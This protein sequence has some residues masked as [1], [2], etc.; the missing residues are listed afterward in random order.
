VSDDRLRALFDVMDVEGTEERLRDALAAETTAAGRAEVL[1]QLAR[2][3]SWLDR[4]DE[5]RAL[6]EE[7]DALAGESGVARARVLLERGRLVRRTEGN[8]AALPLL[9]RGY[10]AALAA[11]QFFVAADA[12]HTCALAGDMPLWTSRG[13]EIAAAHDGA[14]YWRGTLLINL[15]DWQWARGEQAASLATAQAALEAREREAWNPVTEEARYG[16][17]RAL[18]ALGRPAEAIPLLEQVV[19]WL[20]TTGFEHPEAR[21]WQE[22]LAR[23]YDDVGR[24]D[25]AAAVRARLQ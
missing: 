19:R 18:R 16:V 4:L 15:A 7:A 11:G 13:L 20:E 14:R 25:D 21:D 5:A 8:D 17:A 9:E 6:L 2:V 12:A 24:A 22:E 1:T 3:A 10:E 23:A